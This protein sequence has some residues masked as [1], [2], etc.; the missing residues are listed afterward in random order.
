MLWGDDATGGGAGGMVTPG[1]AG[2]SCGGA[3][4]GAGMLG[5]NTGGASGGLTCPVLVLWSCRWW[6]TKVVN[7]LLMA[8]EL[9]TMISRYRFDCAQ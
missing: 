2:A 7:I 1:G 8:T 9:A 3:D 6:M 5:A 4:T